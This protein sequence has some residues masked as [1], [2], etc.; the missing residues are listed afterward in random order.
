MYAFPCRFGNVMIWDS[1]KWSPASPEVTHG[2][3][4]RLI[5]QQHAG[6]LPGNII[7]AAKASNNTLRRMAVEDVACII[8]RTAITGAGLTLAR[9]LN[10]RYGALKYRNSTYRPDYLLSAMKELGVT[11]DTFDVIESDVLSAL[12]S[13]SPTTTDDSSWESSE[14]EEQHEPCTELEKMPTELRSHFTSQCPQISQED[15]TCPTVR[16]IEFS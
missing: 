10:L 15:I 3:P 1:P 12:S 11:F 14:E 4:R 2:F 9:L 5:S 7:I 8:S 13:I 6:I 16:S